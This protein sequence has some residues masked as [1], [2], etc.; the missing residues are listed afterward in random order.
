MTRNDFIEKLKLDTSKFENGLD[1]HIRRETGSYYTSFDIA[2]KMMSD[3]YEAAD[4]TPRELTAKYI[5]EPCAGTGIFVFA[6]L[7]VLLDRGINIYDVYKV[8]NNIFVC[9]INQQALNLYKNNLSIF[10]KEF[11]G[12]N[13]EQK[14]FLRN[15]KCASLL[16]SV[17]SSLNV[18]YVNIKNV[19]KE[20]EL[21]NGFDIVFTNPPYKNL[22]AEKINYNDNKEIENEKKIYE[23]LSHIVK[24][25]FELSS[26]GVLNLYKIFMEEIYK[27]YLKS[28]GYVSILIP[29][30][31]LTDKSSELM[32][33]E[34]IKK[35]KI[36][37]ISCYPEGSNAINA[38]Q[39]VISFLMKK[40]ETTKD[41]TIQGNVDK[42]IVL[43]KTKFPVS[44]CVDEKFG[45]SILLLT[46]KEYEI[47][48]KLDE[49]PK[50]K[51]IL[52][53]NN[54]RGE[55]DITNNKISISTNKT[56][57][58]FYR[59]ENIGFF[60]L[61]D[62]SFYSTNEFVKNSNKKND[63]KTTRLACQQISN[64]SKK[65][66]LCFAYIP[67]NSVLGNS[68]NYLT[69]DENKDDVDYYFL[70]GVL[71]SSIIEW[72]F[73]L[74]SS[75]NHVSNYEINNFP[76]PIYC[77]N[78][79]KIS[80]LVKRFIETKNDDLIEEINELV[81]NAFLKNDQ[82][83]KSE[84]ENSRNHL[85]STMLKELNYFLSDIDI[86]KIDSLL[87]STIDC[88][89]FLMS[90]NLDVQS[91]KY[92]I[93]KS[94]IYKYKCLKNKLVIQ[95]NSFKLSKLDLEMIKN[96]PPGG[97]WKNIP[98]YIVQKSKRLIRINQ[99]GGRTTLYGRIDYNKPSYTITTYFNRPGN[100]TYVHPVHERV[101]SVREAAR[102]QCFPDSYFFFGNK[103]DLLKQIG[104]A[105]PVI[106][107]YNI[108]SKIK[109]VTGCCKSLD[110]FS[111]AGGITYGFKLA[112]FKTCAAT[113]IMEN[114]C[115]TIK[116][117]SPEIN[118]ICG[119]I[120]KKE[121]QNTLIQIANKNKIDIICGG[122][123]CQGF[124]LAGFRKEND[125]RNLLFHPFVN[126][127]SLVRPKIIVFENVEGLLSYKNGETYKEIIR[128]FSELGYLAEG[129]LLKANEYG[130][131]QK[132]KRVIIL[133]VRSDLKILPGEL[134]P[135]KIT[136]K[137]VNQIT[138]K[139]TIYDL[140]NVP[141]DIESKYSSVYS[142]NMIKYLREQISI[143]EYIDS[144]L[145]ES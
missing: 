42:N 25:K 113:D 94:I 22:K 124:S 141:C 119:D 10:A 78:K 5:L 140:E 138:A 117:N 55:L 21:L 14:F 129:R 133:C 73:K 61:K 33:K 132:R 70:L 122:P 12:V 100:G 103:S 136:E 35:N 135:E 57:Y 3:L 44:I 62:T 11:L 65:K 19:F 59:G 17:D 9:D 142:S 95:H 84:N 86:T 28:G 51:D 105:V 137:E 101:I 20:K 143:K 108:A 79:K 23:G 1:T 90:E 63:I 115:K 139:E 112:G 13:I 38:H 4:L 16:Y 77:K 53:I 49:F 96:V 54:K 7:Q 2:Y 34:F 43:K 82:N 67:A 24:Q 6:F 107:A 26:F 76:I 116:I 114:A 15:C 89:T 134:F 47:K 48:K 120:T 110:L 46:K 72:Y 91:D 123:P 39:S 145:K 81:L 75:N 102:F 27:N 74:T 83:K 125:P 144:L 106:L 131:P 99:T 71:N 127:V 31:I 50:I 37:S 104:N 85:S 98:S 41:I 126:I 80:A 64:M 58:K 29:S 40:G 97:N 111:G 87:N 130:V 93:V 36:I 121:L 56:K 18:S 8:L 66:R 45:Y 60:N 52:Y 30:S 109:K 118:V 92:N 32:R 68:S 69:I 128:L 88:E